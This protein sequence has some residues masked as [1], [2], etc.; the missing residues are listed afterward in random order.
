MCVWAVWR[1]SGGPWLSLAIHSLR[2]CCPMNMSRAHTRYCVE[3][4]PLINHMTFKGELNDLAGAYQVEMADAGEFNCF[5]SR[6][7]ARG[8]SCTVC[9]KQTDSGCLMTYCTIGWD[10]FILSKSWGERTWKKIS[11][12]EQR[13]YKALSRTSYIL[14]HAEDPLSSPT[15][16]KW[17]LF[18]VSVALL[19]RD[20]M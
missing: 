4:L 2:P 11:M 13:L 8:L 7:S 15:G 5:W 18:M 1:C 3:V 17:N 16:K 6:G 12:A 19:D 10:C 20:E 9:T 14:W